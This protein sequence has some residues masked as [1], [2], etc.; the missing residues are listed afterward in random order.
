MAKEHGLASLF[1][2]KNDVA[3]K[4]REPKGL[5]P[6]AD[7][8]E[9]PPV[10]DD[11]DSTPLE[12]LNDALDDQDTIRGPLNDL[13]FSEQA[14]HDPFGNI[15]VDDDLGAHAGILCFILYDTVGGRR[16]RTLA[17]LNVAAG[18]G[19]VRLVALPQNAAELDK[20]L[21]DA[22]SNTDCS[23]VAFLSPGT[24]PA[25]DWAVECQ[26]AFHQAGKV[27]GVS[28]RAANSD[29][30]NPWSRVAFFVDEAERQRG[31]AQGIDTVVFRREAL[32]ELGNRIGEAV[33]TGQLLTAI[34]GRGHRIGRAVEAR[35]SLAEPET[36]KD[37][38][39]Q[40]R[41]RAELAGTNRARGKNILF[42]LV[43]AT[44]TLASYPF[45]ILSVR[46]SA[47]RSVGST[48]FR[49][50]LPK[51]AVAIWVDRRVRA[52]TILRGGK[53]DASIF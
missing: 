21:I 5:D 8:E 38:L 26:M 47:K 18:M 41:R 1:G 17:A 9:L 31:M 36:K 2:S 37:V 16:S 45:R 14:S 33:R 28:V 3:M 4:A 34:E 51:A 23:L 42:R 13:D 10:L 53:K 11:A 43:L 25:D 35:V 30:L 50:V 15:E 27:G 24:E 6:L 20:T 19:S 32:M 29:P 22:L 52:F 44:F 40:V 48:Q 7:P 46:K 39:A 12:R 49:E